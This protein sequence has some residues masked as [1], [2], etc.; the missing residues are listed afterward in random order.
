MKFNFREEAFILTPGKSTPAGLKGRKPQTVPY[1]VDARSNPKAL[2]FT[3]HE[4]GRD[5][6]FKA[7]YKI[8]DEELLICLGQERPK[9]F[10]TAG[11]ENL[12]YTF[13]RVDAEK[14]E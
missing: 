6:Q 1:S 2:T 7:I 12:C 9:T 10:N 8:E 11:S 14:I 4:D 5:I 13:K 3:T